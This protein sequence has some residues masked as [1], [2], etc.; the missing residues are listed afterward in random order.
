MVPLVF[1]IFTLALLAGFFVLSGYEARRGTRVFSLQRARLDAQVEQIGFILTHVDFKTFLREE[2]RSITQRIAHD[3]ARIS[4]QAV[5]A[6]ERLL[7]RLVRHLRT[8]RGL[9]VAPR[10]NVR[11]FVRTLSDFKD[12]LKEPPPEI[13]DIY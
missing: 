13:Q 12:Q 9:D 3:V 4:L 8:V 2:I 11:E 5:R 7:T 6:V 1:V 10:E